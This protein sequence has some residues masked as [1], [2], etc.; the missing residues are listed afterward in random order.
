MIFILI[1]LINL[2]KIQVLK[3]KPLGLGNRFC[4]R[5]AE[6]TNE[7]YRPPLNRL[8]RDLIIA[9]TVLNQKQKESN[10]APKEKTIPT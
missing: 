1:L 3:L 10:L 9:T 8:Y 6:P 4:P 7:K 5:P 2:L